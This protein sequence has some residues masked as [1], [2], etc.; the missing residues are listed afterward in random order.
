MMWSTA[1]QALSTDASTSGVMVSVTV[2]MSCTSIA[3][4]LTASGI[5]SGSI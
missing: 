2:L 3:T 5:M 4:N 1:R